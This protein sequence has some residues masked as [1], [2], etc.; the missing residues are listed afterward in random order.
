MLLGQIVAISFASGL[1]LLA[2]P[3][4]AAATPTSSPDPSA[5]VSL[6]FAVLIGSLSTFAI[7]YVLDG[8]N[9]LP[10]LLLMHLFLF[11][12]LLPFSVVPFPVKFPRVKLSNIYILSS[13]LSSIHY[14]LITLQLPTPPSNT[15][16]PRHLFDVLAHHP[17]QASVSTDVL[18]FVALTFVWLASDWRSQLS[19]R[20]RAT[21]KT[22]KRGEGEGMAFAAVLLV[23]WGLTPIVGPAGTFAAY[24]A[25]RE[26]TAAAT[27]RLKAQSEASR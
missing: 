23:V 22:R 14:L 19:A 3:A 21:A 13:L 27:E 9:F 10:I 6:L 18:S 17:A 26:R 12:P 7:P 1:F 16:L 11:F 25:W 4:L 8:S 5:P 20:N 24:L 2:L 15:T